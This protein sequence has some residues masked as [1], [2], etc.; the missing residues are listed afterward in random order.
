[1]KK[2][3]F[4]YWATLSY[5]VMVTFINIG[6]SLLP[7]YSVFKQEVSLMDVVAGVIYLVR[8]F[9]Q[10]EL[11]HF[12]FIAMITGGILSYYLASP[13]IAIASV[14]AFA[15]GE[16][17]DWLIFTYTKKPLK[18]RLLLSACISTP[19]DTLVFLFG[20]SRLNILAFSVMSVGKFLGVL[21]IWW[22][23]YRR[24]RTK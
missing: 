13:Q 2:I 10:Q 3:A 12:I 11:G 6:F 5:I 8:D 7:V 24:S 4:K 1:M 17:I 21:G 20:I 22:M 9:A 18:D 16:L 14:S 23:W 19:F 15:V